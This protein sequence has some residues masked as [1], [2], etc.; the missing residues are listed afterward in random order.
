VLFFHIA[1]A[2]A[3]DRWRK[4]KEREKSSFPK[5]ILMAALIHS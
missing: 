2:H 4:R 5:V 3:K 1:K